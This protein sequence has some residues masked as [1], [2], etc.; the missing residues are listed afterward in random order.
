MNKNIKI[1]RKKTVLILY[2]GGTIGMVRHSEP[3][4]T[5]VVL[6][7]PHLDGSQLKK[8]FRQLVPELKSLANCHTQILFNKDSG[9]MGS[10]EW[11][12]MASV[13]Q[14]NLSKFDGVVVLHGT[15]TLAYSAAALSFLLGN[16]DIPVVMTGA[17][18]PLSDLRTDAKQNLICAVEIAAHGPRQ[19]VRGVSVFF[20]NELFLGTRVRKASA[21]EFDAFQSP[22]AL[23]IARVGTQIHYLGTRSR[24]KKRQFEPEFSEKVVMAWLTP[25]FFSQAL[26]N[27]IGT[28]EAFVL[29]TFPSGTAPTHLESFRMFLQAARKSHTPVVVVSEGASRSPGYGAHPRDYEAGR[30][31]LDEGCLWA[32]EMTPEC[33]YVKSSLILG[34]SDGRQKFSQYWKLEF[35]DEGSI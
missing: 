27:L 22:Q 24:F 33:A 32:G 26:V 16:C 19:A 8:R 15:D 17:Q 20:G 3:M 28:V 12:K 23:P 7:V 1:K 31:L 5:Q 30:V 6:D 35:T 10:P 2:T 29:V 11:I 4:S 13:I 9:H 14:K 25:G 21:S 18:K 34:Q